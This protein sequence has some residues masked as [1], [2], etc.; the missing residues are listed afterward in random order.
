V[1]PGANLGFAAGANAGAREAGGEVLVLL[2]PD[3]LVEP[4]WADAIR[5][6]AHGE[7]SAWMGLVLLD[8]GQRINTSGSR[9]HFTGIAWAGQMGQPRTA[10]P[11]SASEV[12]ALS[13]ACLALPLITWRELDGFAPDFFMYCEDVDLSLRL[14]LHGARLAVIPGAGVRHRYSFAKG[15]YKWRLLERNRWA[16]I[17][18]T[19]PARLLAVTAPALIAIE[20]GI[21]LAALQGGWGR[22]KLAATVDVARAVPRLLRERRRIQADASITPAAFAAVMTSAFDSPYL[23]S[24]ALRRMAGRGFGIYWRL[25]IRLLGPRV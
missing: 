13:G 2:N 19:F 12:A 25:A 4:G 7:W 15:D 1:A 17:V 5:A 14:R 21:W 23:G 16:T 18:R 22:M 9:L 10:A 3:A 11:V 6:P 20:L 24:A 8:D